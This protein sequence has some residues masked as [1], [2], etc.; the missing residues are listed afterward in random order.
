[1]SQQT[2]SN[3]NNTLTPYELWLGQITDHISSILEITNGDAQSL[4]EANDF[5]IKQAL[6][7]GLTP[8]QSASKIVSTL[9]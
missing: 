1:M 5:Y 7:L 2:A 3:M 6:T 9:K 8:L 4:V